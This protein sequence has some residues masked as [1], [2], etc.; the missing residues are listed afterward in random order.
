MQVVDELF[1]LVD[2]ESDMIVW[3]SN[4]GMEKSHIGCRGSDRVEYDFLLFEIV[5]PVRSRKA[6]R[7]LWAGHWWVPQGNLEEGADVLQLG[8]V[9]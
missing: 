3:D 8:G 5:C 6:G 1:G 9:V 2:V 4:F 7:C